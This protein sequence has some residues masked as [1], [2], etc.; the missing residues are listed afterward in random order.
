MTLDFNKLF[1]TLNTITATGTIRTVPEDFKVTELSDI[2]LS[3]VGEHLWLYV[4]K[5]GC[6]TDWVANQLSNVCQVPRKQVGFAGLKDRHAV[7]KQWF[8]VQLSKVT[9]I[10]KIQSALPDEVT[11]LKS[12]M[13]SRKIKTGQLDAN[14]FEIII[15]NIAGDKQQI[16][17]NIISIIENGVPNY[18]GSQRF[19]H[20]MGNI[21][22]C[23][24]WFAGTYKVKSRNLKSLLISTARS[25]IFNV[26]VAKRI[27]DDTWNTPIQ[28]D[29][30]QLN[31]SHSWFPMSDATPE[32][33]TKRLN[34]FDIHLTAAMYGEDKVQSSDDCAEFESTIAAQFPI[35]HTGFEKFRLKQDRRA[36]RICPID[37]SFQWIDGDLKFNFK[38]LPGAYA[39]GIMREILDV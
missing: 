34:E 29:I 33:I 18:F 28:G 39:T 15:R 25:H 30:L 12:K 38:L 21:Q 35:Y 20:D 4:Q 8:S 9:D 10:D 16:E 2:E 3:G 37:F 36:M 13:H 22:K 32:E 11:I 19:G 24:D 5:I 23:Q 27:K 7:T 14:Q 6:N 17:Q 26:I 1:P 31:K